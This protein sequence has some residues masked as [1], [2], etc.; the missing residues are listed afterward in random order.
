MKPEIQWS[1]PP[2]PPPWELDAAGSAVGWIGLRRGAD[3]IAGELAGE[4]I[5]ILGFLGRTVVTAPTAEQCC[6]QER[7]HRAKPSFHA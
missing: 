3:A 4:A 7:A 6:R 5:G 1:P 2:P